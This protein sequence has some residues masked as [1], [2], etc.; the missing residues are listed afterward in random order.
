MKIIFL[1]SAFAWLFT[2]N[3]CLP[4]ASSVPSIPA[5]RNRDLPG[6]WVRNKETYSGQTIQLRFKA[7]H[8]SFLGVI[9]PD[10]SF[11]YLVYPSSE[12]TEGLKPLIDSK[13]FVILDHLDIQTNTLKADPYKYGVMENQSVFTKSGTYTFIMGDNLHTDDPAAPIDRVE[14]VYKHTS[15]RNIQ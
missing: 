13:A 14:V 9:D 4:L 2:T 8:A 1:L 11:F 15:K 7:P 10:G 12:S 6:M 3:L 5:V